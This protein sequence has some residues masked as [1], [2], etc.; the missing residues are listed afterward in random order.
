MIIP[1]D[2]EAKIRHICSVIHDVEWSGVLFYSYSGSIE[3]K[4]LVITCKD[5]YV[6]DIGSGTYT[7]Y[8]EHPSII[9]FRIQN[10][11]LENGIQEGLI[12]SHNNMSTFFSGT[13]TD[14]LIEEGT[15][16]NHFVSLI[17]NN[18]GKYTARITRKVVRNIKAVAHIVYESN[19]YYNSYDNKKID[20][21]EDKK[22]EEDKQEIKKVEEI[23][24]FNLDIE[25]QDVV[26]IF[27]DID[28]RLREIQAEKKRK[29]VKPW[30]S[31]NRGNKKDY[32]FLQGYNKTKYPD[33]Y[34]QKSLFKSN[35]WDYGSYDDYYDDY[36]DYKY[37]YRE[38][39]NEEDTPLC[40]T[41]SFN[42]EVIK[43]LAAQ[44]LTGDITED[45]KDFDFEGYVR[46]MDTLYENKFG[47][48]DE[49]CYPNVSSE[50]INENNRKLETWIESMTDFLVY[51]EDKDLLWEL[52]K[53]YR[54]EFTEVDTAEIC[55]LD[56]WKFLDELPESY[57]KDVMMDSLLNYIPDGAKDV[58]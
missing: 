55:A 34:E 29:E 43:I 21:E 46:K 40:L 44:L 22:W 9:D 37:G 57:V 15:N 56:I 19:S 5:I 7:E 38:I 14:T 39:N 52:K 33:K 53:K 4:D 41:E 50:I 42:P 10:N 25:K 27:T 18:A 28:E 12:H 35:D 48:L 3:D 13:D 32:N 58:K 30:N 51:T 54:R 36:L 26:N 11:L 23:E 47:P 16:S 8:N 2:V 49:D 6:M 45:S 20:V 17:V 1:H 24:Y 31:Y